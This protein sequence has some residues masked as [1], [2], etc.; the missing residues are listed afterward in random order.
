MMV[1]AG[2]NAI[3]G[4]PEVAM[5]WAQNQE[6]FFDARVWSASGTTRGRLAIDFGWARAEAPF[7]ATAAPQVV[8]VSAFLP[9]FCPYL[10]VGVFA[11][12]GTVY[13]DRIGLSSARQREVALLD[14]GDATEAG[15]RDGSIEQRLTGYARLRELAWGWRSGWLLGPPP[16]GWALGQIAFASFWGQFGWMSL[17]IVAD[18]PWERGLWLICGGGLVGVV[19]GLVAGVGAPRRGRAVVLLLALLAIALLFPLLNAYTQPRSQAIQQGRYLFPVLVPLLLL[20]V[21]GW[22]HWV[23]PRWRAG[24][25]ALWL[26]WWALFA[27]TALALLLSVYDPRFAHLREIFL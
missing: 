8:R 2:H 23:P 19:A 13:A 12:E 10:A 1:P 5:E 27:A 24:A 11:D 3:Q 18:T 14:N 22:E 20:L 9:L 17:P 7:T 6:L 4:V 15:L 25:L 21:W 16:L 26:A